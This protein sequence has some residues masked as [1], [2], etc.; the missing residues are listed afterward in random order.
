MKA[1]NEIFRKSSLPNTIPIDIFEKSLETI[2][3]F[4]SEEWLNDQNN[5]PLQILWQRND[6]LATNEL[7]SFGYSL[8]SIINGNINWIE[9]NVEEIKDTYND[10]KIGE[11]FEILT[12]AMLKNGGIEVKYPKQHNPGY[13]LT[14]IF[15]DNNKINISCKDHGVSDRQK[16]F[17]KNSKKF[18]KIFFK[19]C[20]YLGFNNVCCHIIF[21]ETPDTT[22]LE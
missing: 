19:Y 10:N 16:S 14:A 2:A 3:Q 7:Y 21:S 17:E 15:Q 12:A 1:K 6:P 13:D 22:S 20:K 18:E 8:Y 9:K 11:I 5:H 4:F